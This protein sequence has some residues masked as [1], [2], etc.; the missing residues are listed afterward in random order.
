VKATVLRL[1]PLLFVLFLAACTEGAAECPE[2]NTV[3]S[4]QCTN[5][6]VDRFNCGGCGI[7][8]GGDF[9]CIDGG[10]ACLPGQTACEDTC[11]NL[12]NDVRNCGA[13]GN[14]CAAGQ[15]CVDGA[16]SEGCDGTLCAVGEEELCVDT[17]TNADHCGAC[18]N[19][20]PDGTSCLGGV[21]ALG[22][23]Y[24]S[25]AT[26]GSVVPLIKASNTIVSPRATGI[27]SPQALALLGDS[28]VLAAGG[29]DNVLYVFDRAT[30]GKVGEITVA[31]VPNQI[32]VRGQRA[33]VISSGENLVHVIDLTDPAAPKTADQ[34]ALGAGV[35]PMG[36]AFDESGTL[37]ISSWLSS[38]LHSVDFSG[39]LGVAGE[40][41]ELDTTGVEGTPYPTGVAVVGDTVYV[42]L[43]NLDENYQPA[44]NGRLATFERSSGER[45]M[46][47]LGATCTNPG[48]MAVR[49]TEI[50]VACTDSYVSGEVAVVDAESAQ[51]VRRLATG[52]APARVAL[53]EGRPGFVY[54]A[55][56]AGRGFFAIDESGE[57]AT[58]E[59]VDVCPEAA[60]EFNTDVLVVP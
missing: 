21:C 6:A 2:S 22:D 24:A 19:A 59:K 42:S 49:G 50:Y 3:C 9:Q 37:W 1:L 25:C 18:G 43:N 45:G 4:G 16:C 30:M 52:G 56:A 39:N 7:V 57:E 26:E 46:I 44:G 17:E 40:P 29:L 60:W 11:T 10:C 8:C 51:V 14:A 27:D 53:D 31:T 41:I 5:L 58:I 28:Y 38:R 13:C 47:D 33:Y 54:V 36:G 23:L 48:F 15:Q 35:N 34:V 12:D 55:D 32:L 20:C